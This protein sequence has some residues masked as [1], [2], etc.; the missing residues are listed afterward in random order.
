MR[1]RKKVTRFFDFFQTGEYSWSDKEKNLVMSSFSWLMGPAKLFGGLLCQ[2]YGGK[3][4]FGYSK[5]T[6][7]LLSCFIPTAAKFD[8][9]VVIVIRVLQGIAAV[10]WKIIDLKTV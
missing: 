10:S 9:K 7:A 5:F 3:V 6:L 4:V 2:K 8:Y 1:L